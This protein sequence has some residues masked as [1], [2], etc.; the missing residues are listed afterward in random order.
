MFSVIF[1]VNRKPEKKDEY[2][3]LAK[4]LKPILEKV[5][6]FIDNERFDS[7]RRPGW[8]LSHSTWR[9]E[10]SVVRWRTVGEHH[11]VQEK[12]RFEIFQDYH[13]RIGDVVFDTDPP[14]AAPIEEMRF[15]VTEAGQSRFISYVEVTP[16]D[17]ALS[18]LRAEDLPAHLGLAET[19]DGLVDFDIWKSIYVE[20]KLAMTVGWRTEEAAKAW[21]AKPFAGAKAVRQRIVRVVRD[22]SMQDRRE[23]P[24]FYDE[25]N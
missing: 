20:G 8:L 15:D 23:A 19:S 6:G 9:D 10:K 14:P 4:H 18:P 24:Q 5:G 13:L 21:S 17:H 11:H 22:Y 12:G 2:L 7:E 3:E 25:V 1:E 16:A